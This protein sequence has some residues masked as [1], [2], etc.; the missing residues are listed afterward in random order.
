[1]NLKE[2]LK[3]INMKEMCRN[4]NISYNIIR[5]YSC[6]RRKDITEE[7]KA[8]IIEYIKNIL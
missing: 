1:M 8:T 6:G 7:C 2:I 5:D 4:T 3:K